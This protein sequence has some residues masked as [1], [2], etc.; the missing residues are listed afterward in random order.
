MLGGI[1]RRH[2]STRSVSTWGKYE[3]VQVTRKDVAFAMRALYQANVIQM[4]WTNISWFNGKHLTISARDCDAATISPLDTLKVSIDQSERSDEHPNL[5]LHFSLHDLTKMP[6]CIVVHNNNS[7]FVASQFARYNDRLPAYDC[8]CSMFSVKGD[9]R[10]VDGIP[11]GQETVGKARYTEDV[12]AAAVEKPKVLILPNRAVAIFGE[13]VTQSVMRAIYFNYAIDLIRTIESTGATAQEISEQEQQRQRDVWSADPTF[14]NCPEMEILK[15]KA[16]LPNHWDLVELS[17]FSDNN[18]D[19]LQLLAA[20]D[21]PPRTKIASPSGKVL[22]EANKFTIRLSNY[23]HLLMCDGDGTNNSIFQRIN[24]SF[25]PNVKCTP[26]DSED[27][28]SFETL[29][30]IRK[31]EAL[32]FDYT[33]TEA[34]QF[35]QPFIDIE[36]GRQVGV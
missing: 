7:S 26:I 11:Y 6:C 17:E 20:R 2:L 27:R 33:S 1:L 4:M 16:Q 10:V 35:A 5:R 23:R 31:G 21:I 18:V 24:H 3:G 34:E 32:A 28:V 36:S 15:R 22:H 13:T 30:L 25:N 8:N 9:L 12:D 19:D 14:S 29:K